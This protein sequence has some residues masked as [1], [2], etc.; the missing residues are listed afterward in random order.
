M[1]GPKDLC[2][3]AQDLDQFFFKK[4]NMGLLLPHIKKNNL[5]RKEYTRVTT[6]LVKTTQNN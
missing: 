1:K 5:D 3:L 4:T 2:M 6:T